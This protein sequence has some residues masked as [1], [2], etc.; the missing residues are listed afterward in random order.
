[1]AAFRTSMDPSGIGSPSRPR[2]TT[3]LLRTSPPGLQLPLPWPRRLKLLACV[4]FLAI[5]APDL[6]TDGLPDPIGQEGSAMI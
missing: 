2:H 5:D 6:V 4:Q 3:A 1:M